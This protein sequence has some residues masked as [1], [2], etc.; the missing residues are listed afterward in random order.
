MPSQKL[1]RRQTL[2]QKLSSYPQDLLLSLNETYELLEW[3]SLSDTLSIPIGL[4]LNGIYLL[5]RLDQ[6]D[7]VSSYREKD[8]FEGSRIHDSDGIFGGKSGGIHTLV[9]AL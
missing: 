8:I 3:D 5:A 9:M 1:I 6:R 2:R 4:A 7:L